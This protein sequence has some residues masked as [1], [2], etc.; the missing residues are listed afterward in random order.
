MV[1]LPSEIEVRDTSRAIRSGGLFLLAGAITFAFGGGYPFQLDDHS[2]LLDPGLQTVSGWLDVFRLTTTR[3]LTWLTFWLNFRFSDA[4]YTFHAVNLALHLASTFMAWR[5]LSRMVSSPAAFLATVIFALHPLQVEPVIYIFERATLLAALFCW[6]SLDS[7]TSGKEWRAVGWFALALLSKEEAVA[8]PLFVAWLA[9]WRDRT[10]SHVPSLVAMLALSLA[11]GAR[12]LWAGASVP[13]SGVGPH[14]GVTPFEYFLAQ[15][16]AIPRYFREFLLPYGL[17]IE[18]PLSVP[19]VWLGLAGWAAVIAVAWRST[20]LTGPWVPA[21]LLLLLPGSSVFAASDLSA[22]RR[23][24]FPL[25]AFA[26]AAALAA[27]HFKLRLG[28]TAAVTGVVLAVLSMT[29]AT[30]WRDEEA[31]WRRAHSLAPNKIRPLRQLA[32][33]RPPQEALSLLQQARRL[34]PQNADVA[35][36]LGRTYLRMNRPDEALPE[37]GRALAL[38]PN[39]PMALNNRGAALLALGQRDAAIRDFESALKAD[40]C[41]WDAHWNLKQAY[42]PRPD[43]K[44]CRWTPEQQRLISPGSL[45]RTSQP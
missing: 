9:W 26:V 30:P 36:D 38:N 19:P 16:I 3:P 34:A 28:R 44:S 20:R 41:L 43:S 15:G 33:L 37:F 40:P 24:Y 10:L 27:E 31:L 18:S 1:A 39:D 17:T 14:A 2:L 5:V 45:S 8:F 25:A 13:G 35:A 22:D 11:A 29:A 12:V 21:G 42:A 6:L 32:R 4:P 23:M 7:W